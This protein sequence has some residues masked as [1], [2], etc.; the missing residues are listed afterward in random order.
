M[1]PRTSSCGQALIVPVRR[2][3]RFLESRHFLAKNPKPWFSF[4]KGALG[5][6]V[7]RAEDAELDGPVVQV[8]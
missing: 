4:Q 8:S 7:A 5:W 3:K 2:K 1:E 6:I